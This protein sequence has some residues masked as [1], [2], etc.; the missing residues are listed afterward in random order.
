MNT[1]GS[2]SI[3]DR[4]EGFATALVALMFPVTTLMVLL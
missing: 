2:L 4:L 1:L 3:Y